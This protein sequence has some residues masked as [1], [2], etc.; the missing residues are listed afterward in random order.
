MSG[1]KEARYQIIDWAGNLMSKK[2]FANADE[3][4]DYMYDFFNEEDYGEMQVREKP[5]S[6]EMLVGVHSYFRP[7]YVEHSFLQGE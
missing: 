5:D 4:L 3:A 2:E 6:E 1:N 7:L